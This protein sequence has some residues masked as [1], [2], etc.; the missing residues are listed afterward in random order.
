VDYI[1]IQCL[2]VVLAMLNL[3]IVLPGTWLHKKKDLTK[4]GFGDCKWIEMAQAPI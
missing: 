1:R 2:A 4:I 3:Q